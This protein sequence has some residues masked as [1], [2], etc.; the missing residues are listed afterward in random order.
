MSRE[1]CAARV[2]RAV[3]PSPAFNRT[4][5]HANSCSRGSVAA[6]RL[7]WFRW[8][9][10][11]RTR[12]VVGWLWVLWPLAFLAVEVYFTAAKDGDW[13]GWLE[14]FPFAF[15]P[16]MITMCGVHY[17]LGWPG[18]K[19]VLRGVALVVG[20]YFAVTALV[21]GAYDPGEPIR[22]R[23]AAV[24]LAFVVLAAFSTAI[25]HRA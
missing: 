12:L 8:A 19:W 4:R 5:G 21:V 13:S 17:L 9:L 18:S 7:T 10:L 23:A 6:G 15:I 20:L 25:A 24:P 16:L 22:W 14:L 3:P 2:V 11:S 1:S